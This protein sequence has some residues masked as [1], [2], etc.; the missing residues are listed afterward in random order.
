MGEAN[1]ATMSRA[2]QECVDVLFTPTESA[3][4]R[5]IV[6]SHMLNE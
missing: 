6:I 2:L 1:V 4:Q 5:A 3:Q